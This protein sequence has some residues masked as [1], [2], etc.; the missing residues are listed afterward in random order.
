MFGL[1]EKFRFL[2]HDLVFT[3][4]PMSSATK[5]LLYYFFPNYCTIKPSFITGYNF[6]QTP[7]AVF[8][9]GKIFLKHSITVFTGLFG[10]LMGYSTRYLVSFECSLYQIVLWERESCV[11][12]FFKL[13]YTKDVYRWQVKIFNI[14]LWS[15]AYWIHW[16]VGLFWIRRECFRVA[17]FW[18]LWIFG[19]K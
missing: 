2:R 13:N 17:L 4:W 11:S 16:T 3:E 9:S 1:C 18:A 8:K 6:N 10:N 14:F 19:L 12:F 7:C 15:F 5:I